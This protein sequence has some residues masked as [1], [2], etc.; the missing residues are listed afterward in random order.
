LFLE[1]VLRNGKFDAMVK[2]IEKLFE[3]YFSTIGLKIS[4]LSPA[5]T[6]T[7]DLNIAWL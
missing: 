5:A 4:I 1:E 7:R 3:I 6:K 2:M